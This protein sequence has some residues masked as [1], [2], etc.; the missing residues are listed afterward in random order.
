LPKIKDLSKYTRGELG[1]LLDAL[2]QSVRKRIE[3]TSRMGR[4]MAHRQR[5]GAELNEADKRDSA[6]AYF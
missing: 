3:V 6:D 2:K 4:D 5:K 1:I